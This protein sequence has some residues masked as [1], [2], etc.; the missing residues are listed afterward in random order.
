MSLVKVHKQIQH[1]LGGAG[2]EDTP[3]L[4]REELKWVSLNEVDILLLIG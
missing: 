3:V 1:I 2:G 4:G